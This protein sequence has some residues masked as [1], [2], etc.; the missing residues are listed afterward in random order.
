MRLFP[1][2]KNPELI[3]NYFLVQKPK[4]NKM[5]PKESDSRKSLAFDQYDLVSAS[6]SM[7]MAVLLKGKF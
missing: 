2:N 5:N 6:V 4:P 1:T 7:V 3:L